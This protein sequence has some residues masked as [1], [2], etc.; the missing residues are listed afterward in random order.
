MCFTYR[1]S[2]QQKLAQVVPENKIID[3]FTLLSTPTTSTKIRR[4]EQDWLNLIIKSKKKI[5]QKM[6]P[7]GLYLNTTKNIFA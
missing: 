7:R 6:I 3:A 1:K 5:N 4:E 2:V